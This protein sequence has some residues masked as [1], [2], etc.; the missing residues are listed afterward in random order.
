[1]KVRA[2][3][4]F[5]AICETNHRLCCAFWVSNGFLYILCGLL[6]IGFFLRNATLSRF[7]Y[8]FDRL[9]SARRKDCRFRFRCLSRSFPGRK[10][11]HCIRKTT[12][13]HTNLSLSPFLLGDWI[14]GCRD[15]GWLQLFPHFFWNCRRF[16][17]RRDCAVLGIFRKCSGNA[18]FLWIG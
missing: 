8:L 14:S 16:A 11:Y 4:L 7:A 5:A 10:G 3:R 18:Y 15:T 1:M 6:R 13:F 12:Q 9:E 17:G 2:W